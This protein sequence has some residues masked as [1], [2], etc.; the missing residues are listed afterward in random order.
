MTDKQKEL[1]RNAEQVKDSVICDIEELL[2]KY[3]QG[4]DDIYEYGLSFDYVAP[5]TF[6]DQR[7][8]YW[9]YQIAWGGP[10][11]EIRFYGPGA[12]W[13]PV[14]VSFVYLDWFVGHEIALEGHDR[15]VAQRLWDE[16]LEP[17]AQEKFEEAVR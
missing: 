11:Y 12:D 3:L 14:D 9:R 6:R 13:K 5:G 8:G 15:E 2:D 4:K 1:E 16:Y 7:E 10:A 17:W